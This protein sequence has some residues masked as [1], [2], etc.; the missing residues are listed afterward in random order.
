MASLL[1]EDFHFS[2]PIDNAFDRATYL[3]RCWL[4][5]KLMDSFNCIYQAEESAHAFHCFRG[6][7]LDGKAF[8]QQRG[9]HGARR[10][11]RCH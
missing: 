5:N 6:A 1:A 4:N 2:S 9:A 7:N 3:E 10:K 11:T 8:P